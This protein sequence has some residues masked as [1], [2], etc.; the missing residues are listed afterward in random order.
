MAVGGDDGDQG[1]LVECNVI[2]D[3]KKD[4]PMIRWFIH[5]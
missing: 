2:D 3:P 1:W 5:R 4:D